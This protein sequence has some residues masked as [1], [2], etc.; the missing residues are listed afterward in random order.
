MGNYIMFMV[1]KWSHKEVISV[2]DNP[3]LWIKTCFQKSQIIFME[4]GEF[5]S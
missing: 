5:F 4:F 3:S 2:H 1:G